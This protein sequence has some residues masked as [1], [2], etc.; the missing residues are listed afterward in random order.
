MDK[1]IVIPMSKN[2]AQDKFNINTWTKWGCG[3]DT[4]DWS[5]EQSEICYILEGH[6]NV[7]YNGQTVSFKCGD[8]VYFP[9]GLSCVWHVKSPIRKFY[10]LNYPIDETILTYNINKT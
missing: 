8:L 1:I 10:A 2:E 4:F 3:V 7:S 9:E 5:Y 6:A